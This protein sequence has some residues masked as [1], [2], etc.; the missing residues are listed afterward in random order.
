M[1]GTVTADA[2]I[3]VIEA[4][5]GKFYDKYNNEIININIKK[6]LKAKRISKSKILSKN[7]LFFLMDAKT[8]FKDFDIPLNNKIG[9]MFKKDKKMIKSLIKKI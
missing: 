4:L 5:D 8:T 1:G 7:K 2:G 9:S 3:G 6:I